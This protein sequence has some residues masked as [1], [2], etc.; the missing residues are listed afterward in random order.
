MIPQKIQALFEFIDYLDR[1][2][3][4]LIEKY[5]P[6]CNEISNLDI[7]RSQLNP[8]KNYRDK[9]QYDEIQK[10]ITEKFQPITENIYIPTLYKL[11]EL[12]IWAGDDVFTSIWNNNISTI[13]DFR[14]NFTSDDVVTV[15]TYKQKYLSFRTETNSNFLCLQFVFSSLDEILKELFDFFKDTDQNEFERFETKTIEVDSI[16]EAARGFIQTKGQNVRF[17][18]PQESLFD[19]HNVKQLQPNLHNV[20]NEI[21]MGDKFEVGDISNNSGQIIFGK[22][23]RIADSLNGKNE[24]ADKI[25]ELINLIRQEQNINDEQRQSLITNFDKVREEV[26][27]EKPDKSKIFKWLSS[28]KGILEKLVLAHHVTEAVHWVYN[29]LNFIIH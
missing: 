19:N 20:K 13:Y 23:I 21:I 24:T 28:T 10:A 8:K 25:T 1:N 17:S 12:E 3:A 16:K 29:N 22:N 11:K 4:E 2:K 15:L 5:I 14:E 18:I 9:Q 6:L 7:R 26:L 27:E